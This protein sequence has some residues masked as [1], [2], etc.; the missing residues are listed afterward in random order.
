[1]LSLEEPQSEAILVGGG[2]VLHWPE[3]IAALSMF[4]GPKIFWG[5]GTNTHGSETPHW[6]EEL[7]R[8]S[9]VG[10][11]D[12]GG[13]YPWVP[14]AS[15]MSTLFDNAPAPS[16]EIVV[17]DHR[18]FSTGVTGLPTLTNTARM[19][20]AVAYLASSATVI[21]SSYHGAYWATL[22]GRAVIVSQPFS[23]K[24]VHFRHPPAFV[25]DGKWLRARKKQYPDALAFP[26]KAPQAIQCGLR[27][28][29]Q[30]PVQTIPGHS[31]RHIR[32]GIQNCKTSSMRRT[33]GIANLLRARKG[34]SSSSSEARSA[35]SSSPIAAP[36]APS[37]RRGPRERHTGRPCGKSSGPCSFQR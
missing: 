12:W 35:G 18:D 36:Q 22:L 37:P 20:E 7:G 29:P 21:T 9:L 16:V 30:A 1:M 26:Q 32:N 34:R 15:C 28:R 6:P 3:K 14:C 19:E 33:S 10:I 25:S 23:N 4:A 2:G 5:G 17:Y 31:S 13:P 11:R 8:F 27:F 24:F